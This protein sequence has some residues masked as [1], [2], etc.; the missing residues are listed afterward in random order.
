MADR[1]HA[2]KNAFLTLASAPGEQGAPDPAG[3]WMVG[4][5]LRGACSGAVGAFADWLI[6]IFIDR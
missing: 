3:R 4:Q 6:A 5:A 1:T 2:G